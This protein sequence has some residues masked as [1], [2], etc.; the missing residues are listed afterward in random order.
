MS[1]DTDSDEFRDRVDR[2]YAVRA[3]LLDTWPAQQ[4]TTSTSSL[5]RRLLDTDFTLTTD[6]WQCIR[7]DDR[8]RAAWD[9]LKRARTLAELP[10]V[11]AA[12]SGDLTA[13]SFD[14]G[15]VTIIPSTQDGIVYV[16]IAWRPRPEAP[17]LLLLERDDTEPAARALPR[18]R[19]SGDFLLICDKR[20]AA[21]ELFLRL[22]GDPRTLGSFLA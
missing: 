7:R 9:Y 8:L 22:L 4:S 16:K 13:R 6:D 20:L 2:A 19:S 15:V 3:A 5:A 10:R 1:A 21:D 11:A 12:S 17:R 14:N 18:L